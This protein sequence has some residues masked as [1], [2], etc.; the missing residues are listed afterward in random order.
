MAENW[1]ARLLQVFRSDNLPTPVYRQPTSS[2]APAPKQLHQL[3]K[4]VSTQEWIVL[5]CNCSNIKILWWSVR[6]TKFF[7]RWRKFG[8]FSLMFF[9]KTICTTFPFQNTS[10]KV[11]F[12]KKFISKKFSSKSIISLTKI[13]QAKNLAYNFFRWWLLWWITNFK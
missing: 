8:N 7:H 4:L 5:F 2:S 6:A 12:S 10:A 9:V 11:L 1:I 13:L 3:S